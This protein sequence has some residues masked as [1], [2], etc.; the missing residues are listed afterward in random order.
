[1]TTDPL[2]TRTQERMLAD[3]EEKQRLTARQE[4]DDVK[5]LMSDKRGR[6]LMW[7]LLEK[8][9]LYRTSFTGNSETFFREG[10]RNVGLTYMA[11]INEHCPERYNSMVSEQR[12]HDKRN[13]DDGRRSK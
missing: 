12:E 1:M 3:R 10:A 7:G 11:L 8:T 13:A 6:R 9:G 5:W 2:D 4:A